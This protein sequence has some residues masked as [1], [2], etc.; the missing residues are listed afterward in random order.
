VT[1]PAKSSLGGLLTPGCAV[2][3]KVDVIPSF[4]KL[5]FYEE[6]KIINVAFR[7]QHN[8]ASLKSHLP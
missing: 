8:E 7:L 1:K 2:S 4:A 3:G 6:I 5:T